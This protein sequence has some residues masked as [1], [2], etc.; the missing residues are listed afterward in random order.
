[1]ADTFSQEKRSWVQRRL[2]IAHVLN[3][4]SLG[5]NSVVP[6]ERLLRRLV[7]NV[8]DA[9]PTLNPTPLFLGECVCH[10]AQSVSEIA[11]AEQN[12]HS[13][14]VHVFKKPFDGKTS[15]ICLWDSA[16]QGGFLRIGKKPCC[17][18]TRSLL[19]AS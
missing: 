15:D 13:V 17:G 1:M 9:Q 19:A 11:Q 4:T 16:A 18:A 7:Q 12:F 5:L 14:A 10:S 2:R 8:R 3:Q 6:S